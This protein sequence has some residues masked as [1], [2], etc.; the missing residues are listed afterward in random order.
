MLDESDTLFAATNPTPI[1]PSQGFESLVDQ[2][3]GQFKLILGANNGGVP[4]YDAYTRLLNVS[5]SSVPPLGGGPPAYVLLTTA[6]FVDDVA[7]S[8]G[9][10]SIT[11]RSLCL[12]TADGSVVI[13]QLPDNDT[14]LYVEL[15]LSNTSAY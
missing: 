10:P 15:T 4:T 6:V 2:G 8:L 14:V 1:N 9:N 12:K 13:N 11:L 3:S 7:G 5:V